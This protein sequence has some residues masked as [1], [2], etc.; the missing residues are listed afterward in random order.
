V[1]VADE[2]KE[3]REQLEKGLID[4]AEFDELKALVLAGARGRAGDTVGAYKLLEQLGEG[5]MG[6]VWRARHR[7]EAFAHRQGGDVA[8]KLLHRQFAGN[9]AYVERFEAEGALGLSLDHPGIVKVH[10]LVVD[11]GTLGLVMELVEGDSLAHTIGR[12]TGPIPWS[13]ARP[14]VEQLLDAVGH[15]HSRRVVHRDL[16]P[17]NVMLQPG[18]RTKILDFGIAKELGRGLTRSGM[19]MGTI[20]YMA[21]EQY[22]DAGSVDRRA[23]VYAL[24]LTL[25]EMLAGRLPWEPTLSGFQVQQAKLRQDLP[26]PTAF[27]PN[28]PPGVVDAVMKATAV[29]PGERYRSTEEMWAALAAIEE[30]PD[31]AGPPV[32]EDGSEERDG[33]ETEVLVDRPVVSPHQRALRPILWAGIGLG[34][35]ITLLVVVGRDGGEPERETPAPVGSGT[36]AEPMPSREELPWPEDPDRADRLRSLVAGFEDSWWGGLAPEVREDVVRLLT[37]L[38]IGDLAEDTTLRWTESEGGE[39]IATTYEGW[40]LPGGANAELGVRAWAARD[41]LLVDYPEL[42]GQPGIPRLLA[43]AGCFQVVSRWPRGDSV[44]PGDAVQLP[45][46]LEACLPPDLPARHV[47]VR[48]GG[49]PERG[50]TM[51]ELNLVRYLANRPEGHVELLR[52]EEAENARVLELGLLGQALSSSAL[53]HVSVELK[54]VQSPDDIPGATTAEE[55]SLL[56]RSRAVEMATLLRHATGGRADAAGRGTVGDALAPLSPDAAP[57]EEQGARIADLDRRVE[58]TLWTRG[59]ELPGEAEPENEMPGEPITLDELAPGDE[60]LPGEAETENELPGEP[61]KGPVPPVPPPGP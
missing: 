9:P 54:V 5:G 58:V 7:S 36:V 42:V 44:D 14:L 48:L 40:P 32:A 46:W 12:V 19:G 35:L 20:D 6:T 4:R 47:M 51:D 21:P 43:D 33:E 55:G 1:S 22:T 39:E 34:A 18:G 52:I 31:S 23:D 60:E 29:E 56:A 50:W 59:E 25:Y 2:L 13:R 53:G 41:R 3:L 37:E 8:L 24:G 30:L 45:A 27:Y 11:A 17:A 61:A 28:I 38:T 15:A 26:P 57:T 16:K 49:W 10:Q